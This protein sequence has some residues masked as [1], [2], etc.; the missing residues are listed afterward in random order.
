MNDNPNPDNKKEILKNFSLI[1]LLT[2]SFN[3]FAATVGH[4]SLTSLRFF[5]FILLFILLLALFPFSV[6]NRL[7]SPGILKKENRKEVH[8]ILL[9]VIAAVIL[10]ASSHRLYWMLSFGIFIIGLNSISR[11]KIE[12]EVAP[13][14][15]GTFLYIVVY[16]LYIH[17]SYVYRGI[18]FL[19]VSFTGLLGKIIATPMALGPSASGF[20]VWLYFVLCMA[21]LF[22]FSRKSETIPLRKFIYYVCGSV[23]VWSA[24]LFLYGLVL[25]KIDIYTLSQVTIL[26]LVLF[27]SLAGLF[28]YWLRKASFILPEIKMTKDIKTT[29][30]L[31]L[32]LLSTIVLATVPYIYRGAP[33][34]IVFYERDCS[35]GS[36]LPQFPEE[37][38]SLV[39]GGGISMGATLW[40]FEERG[41]TVER[42][43]NENS[44]TISEALQGADVFIAANLNSPFSPEDAE[45]IKDFVRNGG[46]LLLFGEHTNMMANA[47]DFQSGYH[48]LNDVLHSMG[49]TVNMDTAEWTHG[50]WQ[51]STDFMPHPV[52]EG[53]HPDEIR[54]GSVGASLTITGSAEPIMVGRYA[55][56]DDANPLEPGYLGNR[57][58]DNGEQ[59]GD[60]VLAAG[61]RYGSGN[62]LVF[63]DTSYG[64]S[65]AVPGTWEL[66]DNCLNF[67][68]DTWVLPGSVKWAAVLFFLVACGIVFSSGIEKVMNAFPYGILLVGLLVSGT[69]S[70]VLDTPQVQ[71]DAVAWIDTA[72]CNLL[73]THGYKD[74]SIDGL[75][76]NFM[77]NQY[78]P[79]F[80]D[81]MSQLQEGTVLTIIA[82]TSSYSSGEVKKIVS[83][84]E[85]G[86]LLIMS[87]GAAEK[88]AVEPLLAAFQMDVGDIP[89]GPVPWIIETHGRVPEI[90]QENL[91]KYYHEPKFMEAYPVGGSPPYKSYAS[92]TYLGQK[93]ELII[94]RQY[95]KGMVVLIGDSRFLLNE[96]LE[97]S[98][99]P[100]RLGKPAFACLW[101][102]NVEL[103]KDIITDYKEG[104]Q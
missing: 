82:P 53:L 15:V 74:N 16:M 21:A 6:V 10:F 38:E 27:F 50:H 57:T 59:L 98:L 83:F 42:L 73:N 97:Y 99:E 41:Y 69:I 33:G 1:V 96:N 18:L 2:L 58:Y 100:S 84:V 36:Y 70:A 67:L 44:T 66:I 95:G 32:L 78:I 68:T 24:S 14:A 47:V 7:I 62:V 31:L 5:G 13:I 43:D 72:H 39:A 8:A 63:G 87:V 34:K 55:F 28:F 56:S 46:G 65:E 103:L 104:L 76:K 64:F 3:F 4:Y 81:D 49:I 12:R 90:S 48:Y 19:S 101:A 22:F 85:N 80:L 79:L 20:W 52:I 29:G 11:I 88:D 40:Y 17:S 93:Y 30:V 51:S 25:L 61:G 92:L 23:L 77:R 91:D 35:M 75:C 54:T 9:M 102:G 26:Q 60:I 71:T 86:G 45:I 89:L 94:A 37:G